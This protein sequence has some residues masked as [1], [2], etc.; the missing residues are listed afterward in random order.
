MQDNLRVYPNPAGEYVVFETPAT[1]ISNGVILTEG[2]NPTKGPAAGNQGDSSP[3]KAAFGMTGVDDMTVVIID[4][5]GRE[6]LR[7]EIALEKTYPPSPSF[8]RTKIDLSQFQE[9]IYFYRVE[10]DGYHYSGKFV[11]RRLI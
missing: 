9:G 7:K 4:V 2:R 6:V 10:I 3:A 5:F 11:V 1:I 8:R